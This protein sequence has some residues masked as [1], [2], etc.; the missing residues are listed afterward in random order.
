[1]GEPADLENSIKCHCRALAHTPDG[2]PCLPR[3]YADLG[4]SYTHQYRRTGDPADL[5]KSIEHHSHA[6][7]LTPDGHPDLPDGMLI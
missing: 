2:H 3:R 6:L 4:A 1:M 5:E 7:D